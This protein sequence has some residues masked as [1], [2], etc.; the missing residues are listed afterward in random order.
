MVRLKA[1]WKW[2]AHE[3]RRGRPASLPSHMTTADI[4]FAP[5]VAMAIARRYDIEKILRII[6][7]SIKKARSSIVRHGKG[8]EVV[9]NCSQAGLHVLTEIVREG[10]Q[11]ACFSN[12]CFV[13]ISGVAAMAAHRPG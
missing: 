8:Y 6:L 7:A 12:N 4:L 5:M 9:M 2:E 10:G 11:Q 3:N 1:I 13:A